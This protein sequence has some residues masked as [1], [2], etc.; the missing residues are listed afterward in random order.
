[1][2]QQHQPFDRGILL[3]DLGGR[4][5]Q[6]KPRHDVG[7]ETQPL[8]VEL[9]AALGGIGLVG[10]AQHR[11]RVR[12]ID[13]FVRQ[14]SVEQGL[15]RR[16]GGARVDQIGAL[17]PHHLLV[18]ERRPR[19]QFAQGREA[20]GR[21]SRRLDRRHVPA[22]AFDAQHFGRLVEEVFDDGFDRGVAAAVQ[23]ELGIAAEEPRGIDPQRQVARHAAPGIMLDQPLG[24]AVGPQALHCR[25]PAC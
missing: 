6:Q 22:A 1:M 4:L 13:K 10:D 7:D 19:A 9:G 23:D 24:V 2:L 25:P 21:Q 18:G 8:P 15:D 3:E 16:V 5:R 14:E 20:H 11:G 12:V 17:H